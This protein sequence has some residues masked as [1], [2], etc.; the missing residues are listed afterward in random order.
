MRKLRSLSSAFIDLFVLSMPRFQPLINQLRRFE[1]F[2]YAGFVK[3]VVVGVVNT[4]FSYLVYAT[5]LFFGLSYQLANF[6]ALILGIIFSF[7]MQGKFV[8]KSTD[9]RLLG[10]YVLTWTVIYLCVTAAIGQIIK[11]GINA[12]VAGLLTLP[13]SVGLSYFAQ[14]Y[15]VFRRPSAVKTPDDSDK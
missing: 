11:F 1:S 12:Y 3:F 10:R 8:F 14:K 5:F 6:I 15:F 4:G 7:K 13:L 2:R 9:N